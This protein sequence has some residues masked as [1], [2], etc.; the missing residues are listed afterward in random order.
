MGFEVT[1]AFHQIGM[2]GNSLPTGKLMIVSIDFAKRKNTNRERPKSPRVVSISPVAN[3]A[4]RNFRDLGGHPTS[5]GRR[6][7]QGLSIAPRHLPKFRRNVPS[8]H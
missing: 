8:A 2:T 7:P 1:V 6:V 4:A 3:L 5:E